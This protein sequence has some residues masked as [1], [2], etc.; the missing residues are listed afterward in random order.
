MNPKKKK[1][2]KRRRNWPSL[3]SPKRSQVRPI[4]KAPKKFEICQL[5]T[6]RHEKH[7]APTKR[8]LW[9]EGGVYTMQNMIANTDY[10]KVVMVG[11]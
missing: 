8:Y 10:K 9:V 2:K 1:K 3:P 5:L 11:D 7:L 4:Q 6:I